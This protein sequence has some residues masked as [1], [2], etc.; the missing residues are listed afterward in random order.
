MIGR[1]IRDFLG[2][3]ALVQELRVERAG[4]R[5]IMAQVLRTSEEQAKAMTQMSGI[6]ASIYKAYETD[7]SLPEGRHLNEETE[8]AILEEAWYG[9]DESAD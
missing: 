3:D 8:N 6:I 9:S 2:V 5:E 7:G 4:Q 1:M